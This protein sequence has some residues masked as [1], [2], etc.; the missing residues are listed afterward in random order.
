MG[1][2]MSNRSLSGAWVGAIQMMDKED[3]AIRVTLYIDA[4]IAQYGPH[5]TGAAKLRAE[6]SPC[7]IEKAFSHLTHPSDFIKEASLT[8]NS[9][10]NDVMISVLVQEAFQLNGQLNSDGNRIEG[11]VSCDDDL[12]DT[13]S[14]F[15][16]KRKDPDDPSEWITTER[17]VELAL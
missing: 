11:T 17:E 16:L 13:A 1:V 12:S 3:P 4:G 7:A 8:G 14:K 5:I 6:F 10:G 2:A 15:Y 9:T